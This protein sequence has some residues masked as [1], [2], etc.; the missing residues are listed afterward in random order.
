MDDA[1]L[2]IQASHWR[3]SGVSRSINRRRKPEQGPSVS[4][5]ELEKATEDFG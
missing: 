4:D 5:E 2:T 3:T 1:E